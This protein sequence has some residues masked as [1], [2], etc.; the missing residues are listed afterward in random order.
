MFVSPAFASG[1]VPPVSGGKRGMG[2]V[3]TETKIRVVLKRA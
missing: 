1:G 3:D 2:S